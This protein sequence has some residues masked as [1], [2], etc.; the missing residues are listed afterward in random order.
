M[1]AP[2]QCASMSNRTNE[3]A[4][5]TTLYSISTVADRLEVSRDTVRRLVARGDLTAIRIGSN[6][7]VDA[8]ELETF[9]N[10]QRSREHNAIGSAARFKA[11]RA[12][13]AGG[14][15]SQ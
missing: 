3:P 12:T 4:P 8:A 13:R 10:H 1:N 5:G 14:D 9:L 2:L 11:Q 15:D 7:R 6:V